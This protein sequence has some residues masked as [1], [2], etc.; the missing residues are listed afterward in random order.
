MHAAGTNC[1][2]GFGPASDSG[3]QAVVLSPSNDG[4]IILDG[5]AFAQNPIY[6]GKP[7]EYD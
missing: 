2:I 4:G 5:V 6:F 7:Y 1:R 3:V